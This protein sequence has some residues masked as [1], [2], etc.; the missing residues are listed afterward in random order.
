VLYFGLI[1]LLM[2]DSSRELAQARQFRA[3]VVAQTL[4][5]NAAE[6]AALEMALPKTN[7][8]GEVRLKDDDGEMIGKLMKTQGETAMLFDLSGRGVSKGVVEF[9]ASVRI[10]GHI[11]GNQVRIDYAMHTP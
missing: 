2:V 4:A 6:L 1:E 5:E 8:G 3:R 10:R 11:N 7:G 9:E